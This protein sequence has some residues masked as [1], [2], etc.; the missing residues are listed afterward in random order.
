MPIVYNL[1]VQH[2]ANVL[3]FVLIDCETQDEKDWD[4]EV[5]PDQVY[6][7]VLVDIKSTDC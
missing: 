7:S 5:H 3:E 2:I 4:H 6:D 1:R